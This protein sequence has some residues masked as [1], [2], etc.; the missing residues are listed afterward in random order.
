MSFILSILLVGFS[1][2]VMSVVFD[3]RRPARMSRS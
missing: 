1:L 3:S 2:A